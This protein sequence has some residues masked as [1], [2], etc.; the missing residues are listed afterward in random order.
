MYTC[1]ICGVAFNRALDLTRHEAMHVG[2]KGFKCVMCNKAFSRKDNMARHTKTCKSAPPQ[3][4]SVP[5]SSTAE[6]HTSAP[7]S[8]SSTP[9]SSPEPGPSNASP[10]K[11]KLGDEDDHPTKK[12]KTTN[13]DTLI[14]GNVKITR[15]STFHLCRPYW[16]AI[17]NQ[18]FEIHH[19]GSKLATLY[20]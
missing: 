1:T 19:P 13:D 18:Y 8:G 6:P 5:D 17:L 12:T 3:H 9:I 14:K 4:S 15:V 7:V 2:K 11:R 16:I 10:R 20:F